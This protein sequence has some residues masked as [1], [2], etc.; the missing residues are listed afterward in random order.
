MVAFHRGASQVSTGRVADRGDFNGFDPA[1]DL[2][3]ER[4]RDV[5]ADLPRDV[6]PADAHGIAP[7]VTG[8]EVA[9]SGDAAARAATASAAFARGPGDTHAL[10]PLDHGAVRS[11]IA[12][13]MLAMFLSALEQT[14]VAP[15]L[16]AIGKSLVDIDDLSWVV[17]AYL[18]SATAAT[19]LF[20]KLT[21]IYGRR[22]I[23][24]VAIGIFIIGS[25]V[26]ALAPTIWFLIIG[27]A[28]QGFG[29]GGLL[30]IAQTIIA[31]LLTPR[32]R[33]VVQGYTAV[34]FMSASILG[35]VL[36][37]LLT[38]HLHWSFIFWINLPLGAIAFVMT[39]RALRRLPRH[40][41]PHS[42]DIPGVT[43]MMVASVALLLALD[44][45]GTH[46][47]WLSWPILTLIGGSAV[48][49]VL[50]AGRL[51]TAREPLIPLA[52]LGG[53]V[54]GAITCAAF[55]SIG[56]IMG[57]TI[58]TPLYCQLVL[59]I[60]ASSSSVALIAFMG[61][62]VIGSLLTGR[63][64][65]RLTRY[66][67]VPIAG[68]IVAL[69]ALGILAAETG[70]LSLAT[71]TVLLGVL[72]AA[73]GPMYP[74]STI[75]MQ[76]A[77]KT[78]QLGIATG[79]LNFFRLL[80]GAVIVAAFGAIVLGSSGDQN[81]VMTLERLEAGHADFAPAFRLVFIAA[82]VFLAIALV[83]LFLVEELPMHG[84]VRLVDTAAE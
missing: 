81:T 49:W 67:R 43:L 27:R 13:I 31:D 80:G 40:D 36:G 58:F 20:G 14:I 44:W 73:L 84:P 55:F 56:T 29:G 7:D 47:P 4:A 51:L 24:L 77:V 35:P 45:G 12:G 68:L 60:S 11:I 10:P 61:G 8:A 15:A 23:M 62:A 30:P 41:R 52:I 53:R 64:L 21:D 42:L 50:F 34:V 6:D 57:V 9:L 78:H 16:T 59:G 32:E 22:T 65:V 82:A 76:N 28:L 2:P 54:T 25:L 37:G 17:T 66:M 46:Y 33:P 70:A 38:D 63:L 19:P 48:L 72:G 18:L 5:T 71:F 69:L 79:A 75:V 1:M 3:R 26:C 83:C 39:S 74:T